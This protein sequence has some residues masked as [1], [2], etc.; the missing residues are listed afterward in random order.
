[1]TDMLSQRVVSIHL[2]VYTHYL[3]I[4][5]KF[6]YKLKKNNKKSEPARS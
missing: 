1:M 4:Y 5:Y 3:L 2:N 6:F